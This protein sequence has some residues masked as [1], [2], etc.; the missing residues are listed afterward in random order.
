MRSLFAMLLATGLASA[1]L[2]ESWSFTVACDM[3]R[4]IVWDGIHGW[5]QACQAIDAA[6]RGAFLVC[7]G[8]LDQQYTSNPGSIVYDVLVEEIGPD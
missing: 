3:R 8:D 1:A 6:G 7:P 5:D 2:A 4:Y